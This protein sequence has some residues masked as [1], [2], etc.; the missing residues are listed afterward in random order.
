LSNHFEIGSV[1]TVSFSIKELFYKCKIRKR[2]PICKERLQHFSNSEFSGYTHVGKVSSPVACL[3]DDEVKEY[4]I[5]SHY[6]CKN[7]NLYFSL[8]ELANWKEPK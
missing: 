5:S 6:Y 1:Y 8:S 2:C 4:T 7:C 3:F